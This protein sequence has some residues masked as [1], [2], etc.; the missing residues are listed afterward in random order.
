[1]VDHILLLREVIEHPERIQKG[2]TFTYFI[3]DYCRRLGRQKMRRT[4]QQ[5][6]LQWQTDWIWHVDHRHPI[7]YK[8]DCTQQFTDAKLVD[9][10]IPWMK[11]K[12]T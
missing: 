11:D 1:L 4:R 10:K 5:Q 7:A 2:E 9:K 12:P 3:G 6:R 8:N